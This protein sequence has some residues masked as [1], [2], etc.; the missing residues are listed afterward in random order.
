MKDDYDL[1]QDLNSTLIVMQGAHH[2][3]LQPIIPTP[4]GKW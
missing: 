3:L 4:P 2:V 1:L